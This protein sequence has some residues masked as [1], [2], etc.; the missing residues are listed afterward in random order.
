MHRPAQPESMATAVQPRGD[1]CTGAISC[2][3]RSPQ[4][5]LSLPSPMRVPGLLLMAVARETTKPE[6][7]KPPLKVTQTTPLLQWDW[8]PLC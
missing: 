6:Q 7:T 2:W 4:K 1:P 8:W 3:T 5:G